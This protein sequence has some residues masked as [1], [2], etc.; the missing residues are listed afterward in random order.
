[1]S[2]FST[3][4]HRIKQV[5]ALAGLGAVL[6]LIAASPASAAFS[7]AGFSASITN[8]VAG[9]HPD[10][11]T[12]LTFPM[13]SSVPS[14]IDGNVKDIAVEL[15][16]G[17]VGDP[18][19]VP[20]CLQSAFAQGTCMA[21]AQVGSVDVDLIAGAEHFPVTVPVF[22]MQPR[23]AAETAEIAFSIIGLVN[24]HMPTSVR[25]DGD[26]G[27]TVSSSGVSR[28]FG[29]ASVVL[30]V[31]GVPA[32]PSHDALRANMLTGSVGP[33]QLPRVPFLTNPGRCDA[34]MKVTAKANSYQ[35]PGIFSDAEA[36]L[37][38]L[39]GCESQPFDPEFTL[40]PQSRVAG[41]PSAYEA[42]LTVPQ[43]KSPDGQAA[44]NLRHATVT[45]PAGVRL[46][47][48]A[49]S[50]LGACSDAD[51]RMGSTA[52]A[53]CP[54]SA[55]V[56]EAR[57]D[58]P[59]LDGPIEGSVYLRQPLPGHL[60]RIAL[61]ADDFGIHMKVPGEVKPDPETGQLTATFADAPQLPFEELTLAFK[62]GPRAALIN[63]TRC[64][65]YTTRALLTPWSSAQAK[66]SL[67]SFTIDQN[68][69]T[70]D[71]F[72][73]GL[74]AGTANPVAGAHSPFTLRVTGLDGQQN[75]SAIAATLPEGVLAELAGI[76]L[77]GDALAA[78]GACPQ[79]S[80]IGTATVGAG[81]GSNPIY[82]PQPGK[83]PTG[84]Y[85]AGPYKEAPY[86]LVVRVPAQAG[87]F[88][89]GTVAV[90]NAL[91]VDPVT[92]QVT[93]KSDPLPQI[94]QGIPIDYRD[95]RVEIDRDDFT[96]NPTSCDPM[97]VSSAITSVQGSLATPSSRFQV[98]DCERLGFAPKLAL[99][100]SG[101]AHRAAHPRLQ[102]TL[103]L[104]DGG[105]NIRKATVLLPETELLENAHIRTICTRVQFN[106]GA[107][108]GAQCPKGSVYGYAKAWTPLLDKPLEGPVYLRANGGERELPDLVASLGGQIHVNLVGYID[109]V[110]E[111][112]RNTFAMVP[113]AP[114]SKFVLNMQ[115]GRKSLLS[116]NTN[117]CKAKPRATV[118]FDGHNGKVHDTNPL[119]KVGG[120]GK[121]AKRRG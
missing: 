13:T 42:T 52:P 41:E 67:S 26:Y 85:L 12:D 28:N 92:T 108:N 27:L 111:R 120:C 49:A 114:V 87:P 88:D 55:K 101:P 82:V 11:T 79:A 62:G 78:T 118:R 23:N 68:C 56:G 3:A 7:I 15:P 89:L 117:L 103:S 37:P 57:I 84:V 77:C 2:R 32:D 35:A 63:P 116:N 48:S 60:F 31:W 110:H 109:S 86:S 98:T 61:V 107:G 1:M 81:P 71:R 100:F 115:G 75:M 6:A 45:L 17:L 47:P 54:D 66:E 112:I 46:S 25:T 69:G 106:A 29:I 9:A 121:K 5:A 65:T 30:T 83:A 64:G 38:Q 16:A 72:T 80:Q 4:A 14:L 91:Y 24:V 21:A 39:S 51:L 105:A 36:S 76:P 73:P 97:S 53:T 43:N 59:V 119:V 33:S 70:G 96:L 113:D 74:Q 50:G 22:N 8:S 18:T 10:L 94:L 34:P 19:A 102:A 44:A 20:Q 58:T 99:R 104:P 95:V 90:R 93:A 40:H